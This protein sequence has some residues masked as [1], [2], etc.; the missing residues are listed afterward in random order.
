MKQETLGTYVKKYSKEI[1]IVIVCALLGGGLMGYSAKKHKVTT[2]T[3]SRDVVIAHNVEETRSTNNQNDNNSIVYEDINMM[4]TYKDIV[5]NNII[6]NQAHK[7]LNKKLRTKYSD[8]DIQEAI[9]AKT[10]QQ[11]LVL[12]IKVSTKSQNDSVAIVNAVSRSF[13]QQLPKLQPGAG[14]VTL[15]QKATKDSTTSI[16]KPSVK[17][18]AIV[19]LALGGLLGLII[20]LVMTTIK[21]FGK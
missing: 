13:K 2:Y 18:H 3:A 8:K 10:S 6:A 1:I 15:L 14:H 4:P 21:T 5:E 16:T 7:H 20:S 9:S 19:G 11:S 17:K 12:K